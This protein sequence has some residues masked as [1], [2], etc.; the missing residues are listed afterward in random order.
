MKQWPYYINVYYKYT[1]ESFNINIELYCFFKITIVGAK[2]P[3]SIAKIKY[4]IY[5][6][7]FILYII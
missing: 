6:K 1:H 2:K 4:T 7:T 3:K 5:L